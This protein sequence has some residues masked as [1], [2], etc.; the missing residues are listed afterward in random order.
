[1]ALPEITNNMTRLEDE[2]NKEIK[3]LQNRLKRL[4]LKVFD[5]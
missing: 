5:I 1:M 4:E 2:Q 3:R